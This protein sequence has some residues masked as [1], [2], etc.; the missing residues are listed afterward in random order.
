MMRIPLNQRPW[1]ILCLWMVCLYPSLSL[2]ADTSGQ[3]ITRI[4]PNGSFNWSTGTAT[5]TGFGVPPRNAAS[6]VQAR[7][8]TRAAA[9][10]VALANLLEV[11]N[12]IQVDA[13]TTVHNYVTTNAE[14]QTHVE[15]MVKQATVIEEQE[16][17][18]GEF[19]TTVQMQVAGELTTHVTSPG[20]MPI[21]HPPTAPESTA[22]GTTKPTNRMTTGS[23]PPTPQP[24]PRQKPPSP[25]TGLLIDARN[26][27]AQQALTPKI[28][29]QDDVIYGP[30]IVDAKF[31]TGPSVPKED[32][33]R[34]AWYFT[35]ET[36]ARSHT[37]VAP[38]PLVIKAVRAIG[39]AKT[40]LMIEETKAQ[41]IQS[42]PEYLDLF[43]QAKVVIIIDSAN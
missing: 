1:T 13:Q 29:A 34:I 23:P 6:A 43:K 17:P 39:A 22:K 35:D 2:S 3:S 26:I 18:T 14:V 21:P 37:K 15:G 9:W 31:I 24:P 42:L 33:N 5:A 28:F 7:E 25:Y 8:M 11:V 10:S 12:G 30:K 20:P 27:G 40:D 19:K 41:R 38:N 36:K 32:Q 4:T 16:L